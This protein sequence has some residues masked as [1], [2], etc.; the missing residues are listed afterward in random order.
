MREELQ[1]ILDNFSYEAGLK[2]YMAHVKGKFFIKDMLQKG[3]D[4]YND[5]KLRK[6][7]NEAL[8][9]LP[10][11]RIIS[12]APKQTPTHPEESQN[13]PKK[14]TVVLEQAP[15][16]REE[17]LLDE[18]WKPLYKEAHYFHSQ[19]EHIEDSEKRKEYAFKILDLMDQVEELWRKND[20]LKVH[21][22]LPNYENQG[23]EDLTPE[24]MFTRIRTIRSY[25]SKAK[26]G[27]LN[28]E[29]IPEWEN[30]I[31]ELEQK[32]RA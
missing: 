9:A 29:K 13:S 7:L 24:Q 26:K 21:G 2:W 19:L 32:S 16:S 15:A 11:E 20:F 25:I 6:E 12:I 22:Q 28:A 30:E 4:S 3:P 17:L 10:H 18:Q 8:E 27:K 1:S 5:L 14:K 23:M 31:A